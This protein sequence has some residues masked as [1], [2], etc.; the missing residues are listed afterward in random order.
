MNLGTNVPERTEHSLDTE[1]RSGRSGSSSPLLHLGALPLPNGAV[2]DRDDLGIHAA[3]LDQSCEIVGITRHDAVRVVGKQRD[4][5]VDHVVSS[6][7]RKQLSD[8]GVVARR[9][10]S[11]ANPGQDARKQ[12]LLAT[13]P[14]DLGDD[15]GAGPE[16][17]A[18]L[19]ENAQHRFDPPISPLDSD[20]RT[21]VEDHLHAR[22]ALRRRDRPRASAARSSSSCV[23]AASSASHRS[24]ASP[25]SS[26]RIRSAVASAIQVE[27]LT[28]ARLAAL[29]AAAPSL[30]SRAIESR[31]TFMHTIVL[32]TAVCVKSGS[33][34]R[35]RPRVAVRARGGS[36]QRPCRLRHCG[37]RR[38]DRERTKAS[39]VSSP[40]S[41]IELDTDVADRRRLQV[42][43]QQR[44]RP[45][46]APRQVEDRARRARAGVGVAIHRML[47]ASAGSMMK[48]PLGSETGA[49]DPHT[50][51]FGPEHP[52]EGRIHHARHAAHRRPR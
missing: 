47:P 29:R 24:S 17:H 39:P 6:G 1:P 45:A 28:L 13:V 15:G 44:G 10:S 25:S 20:E 14:P 18:L 40:A 49:S 46:L 43:G 50:G 19:V 34:S 38:P 23:N 37:H 8:A 31:S 41:L 9:K 22:R 42:H 51:R 26:F 48:T 5:T 2:S 33:A 4:M 7:D 16:R 30:G 36:R 27:R 52:V 12:G 32:H 3:G 11:D 35:D 21:G